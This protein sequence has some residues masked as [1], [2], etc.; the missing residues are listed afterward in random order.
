[1]RIPRVD[2]AVSCHAPVHPSE[3]PLLVSRAITNIF[4]G[5]R[6]AASGD[7]V[8]FRSAA[9]GV[10]RRVYE[11]VRSRRSHRLYRRYLD[12]NLDGDATWFYLNKQAAFADVVALC[13][14]AAESP[15]GPITVT[16]RSPGIE[17]VIRWL[18]PYSTK[19]KQEQPKF[20][21]RP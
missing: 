17:E 20:L 14:D 13:A 2:C 7:G 19:F 3:D 8:G 18:A 1:M 10:L 11:T 16:I 21:A 6:T 9:P 5:L 15:L 4:G 12:A